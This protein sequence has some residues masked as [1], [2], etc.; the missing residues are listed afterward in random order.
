MK[1]VGRPLT[2]LGVNLKYQDNKEKAV[3]VLEKARKIVSGVRGM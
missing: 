2:L 1:Q 3:E